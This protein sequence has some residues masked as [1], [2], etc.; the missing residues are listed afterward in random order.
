MTM[1]RPSALPNATI[2]IDVFGTGIPG[3]VSYALESSGRV[4]LESHEIAEVLEAAA[5]HLRDNPDGYI[6]V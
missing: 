3:K 1:T 5:R 6:E 4:V 2:R